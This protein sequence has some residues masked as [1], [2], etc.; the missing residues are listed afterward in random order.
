MDLGLEVLVLSA[1][2]SFV[3]TF[4]ALMMFEVAFPWCARPGKKTFAE[5]Y[6]HE[7]VRAGDGHRGPA[8]KA[9]RISSPWTK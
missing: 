8:T 6:P 2:G 3:G 5:R 1:I 4:L 7:A 9:P